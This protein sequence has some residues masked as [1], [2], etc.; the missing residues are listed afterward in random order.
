ML[1][2]IKE[3][4]VKMKNIKEKVLKL[5][6]ENPE[7]YWKITDTLKL[8]KIAKEDKKEGNS[9]TITKNYIDHLST[10]VNLMKEGQKFGEKKK[11]AEVGKVIDDVLII[12]DE[13]GK[14][15]NNEKEMEMFRVGY[16]NGREVFISQLKQRLG[17]QKQRGYGI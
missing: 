2:Y 4:L 17:I 8:I 7:E 5:K 9:A 15:C 3:N 13:V 14:G 6:E 11:L 1:I 16:K 10:N 12:R